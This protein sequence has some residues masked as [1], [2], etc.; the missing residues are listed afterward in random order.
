[1]GFKGNLLIGDE[2]ITFKI[3][4]VS[5]IIS[6][7]LICLSTA[8]LFVPVV[9]FDPLFNSLDWAARGLLLGFSSWCMLVF[10]LVAK[11]YLA[12]S[13]QGL[14]AKIGNNKLVLVNKASLKDPW[15]APIK[16]DAE[17]KKALAAEIKAGENEKEVPLHPF[18]DYSPLVF[19]WAAFIASFLAFLNPLL[20]VLQIYLAAFCLCVAIGLYIRNR[21][22]KKLWE[23]S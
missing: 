6:V 19:L 22:L 14:A 7:F 16:D 3:E 23:S 2:K 1:M 8:V 5:L 9:Y 10:S 11:D 20:R 12:I 13:R 15:I 17:I 18:F 21:S 4:N